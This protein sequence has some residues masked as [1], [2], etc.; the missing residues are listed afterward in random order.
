MNA[1][2]SFSSSSGFS[3]LA[4]AAKNTEPTRRK[5]HRFINNRYKKCDI[6]SMET[7]DGRQRRSE[8]QLPNSQSPGENQSSNGRMT[9]CFTLVK[10]FTK[11][12]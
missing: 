2:W 10:F 1:A 5:K 6:P 7:L 8:L 9:K 3:A 12:A 4:D 11:P